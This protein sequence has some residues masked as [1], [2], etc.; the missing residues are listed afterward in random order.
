MNGEN[1]FHESIRKLFHLLTLV[2]LAVYR[3]LGVSH[4]AW[5]LGGWVAAE[6]MLEWARLRFPALNR[7]L[8]AAFGA[9]PRPEEES[10]ISGIFWTA[11]GCWLTVLAFGRRP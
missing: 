10:R 5:L 8:I 11:L 3:W 9:I 7:G 6:G 1:V 4:T 2:Y